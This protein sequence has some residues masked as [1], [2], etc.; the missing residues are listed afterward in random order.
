M[1]LVLGSALLL[2]FGASAWIHPIVVTAVLTIAWA[3]KSSWSFAFACSLV[4]QLL[5][6]VLTGTISPLLGLP[7]VPTAGALLTLLGMIGVFRLCSTGAIQLPSPRTLLWAL[8]VSAGVAGFALVLSA[9]VVHGA[10]LEWAMRNDSVWNL[11]SARF[12]L[13]DGGIDQSAHS[14]PAPL[15]AT[16]F[17][18]AMGV[19]RTEIVPA[20][21]LE[22]DVTQ[23]A[24]LWLFA[25]GTVALLA[26]LA[27]WHQAHA[28]GRAVR[29]LAAAGT[30]IFLLSWFV[31]GVA[32]EFGFW[33]STIV[34]VPLIASWVAWLDWRSQ[35][36]RA[37]ALLSAASVV[38]LA[39]WAPAALVP[40]SFALVVGLGFATGSSRE[41]G[42]SVRRR[43]IVVVALLAPIPAYVLL[44]TLPDVRREGPALAVEGGFIGMSPFHVAAVFVVF[45]IAAMRSPRTVRIGA[46]IL[47]VS[48]TAVIAYLLFQRRDAG[49]LW[50]YYP[51]KLSWLIVILM[52]VVLV[53][54]L[55]AL[56]S[57][58]SHRTR[59]RGIL[60]AAA[61]M[62]CYLLVL[63]VTPTY[64]WRTFLTPVALLEQRGNAQASVAAE[65]LFGLAVP[66]SATI[67]MAFAGPAED[68][69]INAWLLQ[70]EAQ[71]S[72][73][74]IRDYSYVLDSESAQQV[75]DAIG[76]W[77]R[78]VRVV[79]R[80]KDAADR[81]LGLCNADFT[82]EVRPAPT[83]G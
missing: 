70:L 31:L 27:C 28:I 44:V 65:E 59:G 67:A 41:S 38:A 48:G 3:Q 80:S 62:S 32:L 5:A 69:L 15:T 72:R 8:V 83:T 60:L 63:P 34:L 11:V 42:L 75:C 12:V 18:L 45:A 79:T 58:F 33:N 57:G 9:R 74:R 17:A 1:V 82:V 2:V 47:L 30:A 36:L 53:P 6:V 43:I 26:G 51:A 4:A 29:V 10:D 54:V 13:A 22:H 25:A 50:G 73:E 23:A 20:G 76:A 40:A 81:L 66:G 68:A 16:L 21:L 64:G 56:A 78:P 49:R 71:N 37:L 77:S 24:A 55:V 7:F 35:P 19:G 52:L 39:T 61:V 14:N 46:F